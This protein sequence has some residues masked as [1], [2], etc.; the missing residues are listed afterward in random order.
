MESLQ[1]HSFINTN[2]ALLFTNFNPDIPLDSLQIHAN[3]TLSFNSNPDVPLDSLED[4][5]DGNI[6]CLFYFCFIYF[7]LVM[8]FVLN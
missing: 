6:S 4:K 7:Q 1:N 2:E 3:E 5:A 8:L